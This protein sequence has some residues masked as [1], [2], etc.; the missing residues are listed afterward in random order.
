MHRVPHDGCC[1]GGRD[2]VLL[3]M[4]V[5]VVGRRESMLPT[6]EDFVHP[7]SLLGLIVLPSACEAAGK[8]RPLTA[9]ATKR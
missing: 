5:V 9:Q 3:V 8:R 7:V 1:G 2:V 6:S 4:T